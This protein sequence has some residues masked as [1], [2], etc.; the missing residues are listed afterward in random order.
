LFEPQVAKSLCF[1]TTADGFSV[2]S[3]F[4]EHQP[5]PSMETVQELQDK[6]EDQASK[7]KDSQNVFL[8]YFAV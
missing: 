2:P 5:S 1:T 3:E 7:A 8:Y 4:F 6:L